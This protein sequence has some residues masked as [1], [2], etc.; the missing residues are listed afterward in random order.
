MRPRDL[1]P[2]RRLRVEVARALVTEPRAL[3][4]DH[5]ETDVALL[6]LVREAFLAAIDIG[7]DLTE[8]TALLSQRTEHHPAR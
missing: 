1:P 4:V 7:R 5:R 3:L 6:Q 2:A 8:F